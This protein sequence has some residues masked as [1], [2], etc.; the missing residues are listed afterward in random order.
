M[1]LP[2]QILHILVKMGHSVRV[3]LT[4]AQSH[5]RRARRAAGVKE[6]G[7]WLKQANGSRGF[8]MLLQRFLNH[9]K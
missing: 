3:T 9:E 1:K 5:K 6:I 7:L 2:G 4:G 8:V